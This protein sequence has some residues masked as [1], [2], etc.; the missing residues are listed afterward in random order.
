MESSGA[1]HSVKKQR[2]SHAER[3]AETRAKIIEAVIESISEVGFQ[4]TTATEISTRAGVTWGAV[5]HHFGGKDGILEAVLEDTLARFASRLTDIPKSGASLEARVSMFIDRCW[6]HYRS[7]HYR[8]TFEILLNL[9]PKADGSGDTSRQLQ[10]LDQVDHLWTEIF[11]DA[12]LPRG[13]RLGLE[14]YTIAV[15]SGLATHL[16]L[17][18]KQPASMRREIAYLKDAVLRGLRGELDDPSG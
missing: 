14:S 2:R 17:L 13:Q 11:A 1:K 6:E 16:M 4:A 12:E 9:M 10:I 8:S 15:L 7:P 5:Q 18:G 3:S